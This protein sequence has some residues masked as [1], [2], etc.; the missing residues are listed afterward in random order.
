MKTLTCATLVAGAMALAA[1]GAHAQFQPLPP[2][3]P[4]AAA[5]Q[6]PQMLVVDGHVFPVTTFA[7][8]ERLML[9]GAGP[10][11]S[12]GLKTI[13]LGLY[14]EQPATTF[15][16]LVADPGTK[17]IQFYFVRDASARDT[18]NALLDRLRQNI[19]REEFGG[20]IVAISQLGGVFGSRSRFSRGDEIRIDYVPSTK[21]T[22]FYLNKVKF[23]DSI[24][25]ESFY[26]L[27]LKVFAGPKVREREVLLK[28]GVL[29]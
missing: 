16:E 23:G 6:Q 12:M 20:N 15:E 29:L 5:P 25:G 3:Q 19:T 1:A 9:N 24:Q 13:V 22:E 4:K 8:G 2:A 27:M 18:S 11:Y 7:H 21:V 17:R 26:P 10:A 28:G 14:L